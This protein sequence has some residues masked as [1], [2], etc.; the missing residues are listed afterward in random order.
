MTHLDNFNS[1]SIPPITLNICCCCKVEENLDLKKLTGWLDNM[2]ETAV[3]VHLPRFRIE[4]SFSLKEQLQAMGLED[5]FSP[6]DASLPGILEDEANDLYISDAFH[7][8]F[9]EVCI[10]SIIR[11]MIKKSIMIITKSSWGNK[12]QQASEQIKRASAGALIDKL[13]YINEND[14]LSKH[15][16]SSNLR[17]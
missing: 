16:L 7:K 10:V 6:K 17:N 13:Y 14:K 11:I 12:R 15:F 9:L 2:R 5:L 4:D 1:S 3:S 8:A